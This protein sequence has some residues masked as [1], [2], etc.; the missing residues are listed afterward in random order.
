MREAG[1]LARATARREFKRWT[2]GPD[3]SP[4]SE[5]DIAVNDFLHARL[6]ALAPSA[7]WISEETE[8][9]PSAR[10]APLAWI[11]D[12]IDGTRAYV[13]GFADWTVS[14][15]LVSEGRPVLAALY[16]PV[17]EEMFVAL[18][19]QGATRNDAA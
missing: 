9:D 11:V 8:D 6:P 13:A 3:R 19:G 7:G 15:A 5:G 1:E 16:A 17:S 14:V 18:R 12:P 2:K 4:V 10:V